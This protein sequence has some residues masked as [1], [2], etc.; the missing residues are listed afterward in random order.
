MEE[1]IPCACCGRAVDMD[2]FP[3]CGYC[4]YINIAVVGN[5]TRYD[6]TI[7]THRMAVVAKLTGISVVAYQYGWIEGEQRYGL[8]EKREL[9]LADGPACDRTV[10]WTGQSFGQGPGEGGERLPIEIGYNY[11]GSRRRVT[12]ELQP[13]ASD[14]YWDIGL[15]INEHLEL[16]IH[17]GSKHSAAKSQPIPFIRK[18]SESD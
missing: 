15:E 17:L 7:R 5:T 12:Q 1:K 14:T 11:D 10:Y 18:G 8:L 2:T 16:V 3:T 9:M 6:E 13:P 4:G